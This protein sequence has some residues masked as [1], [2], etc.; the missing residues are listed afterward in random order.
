M[1]WMQVR[2]LIVVIREVECCSANWS[3]GNSLLLYS[4]ITT[5]IWC[6]YVHLVTYKP[7]ALCTVGTLLEQI[8]RRV[9]DKILRSRIKKFL[10]C[11]IQPSWNGCC[12]F[13]FVVCTVVD[14]ASDRTCV[15]IVHCCS[16]VQ[17]PV[18]SVAPTSVQHQKPSPI[19][20]TSSTKIHPVQPQTLS[21]TPQVMQVLAV[22][23]DRVHGR[24]WQP[25]YGVTL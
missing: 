25:I 21:S 6:N 10:A 5:A 12:A 9:L 23:M 3:V 14:V 18:S 1:P 7:S 13:Q 24:E 22:L 19:Y 8:F 17:K 4:C 2:I 20:Q 16:L 15:H 11:D